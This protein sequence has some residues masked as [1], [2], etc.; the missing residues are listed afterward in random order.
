MK[1]N[2]ALGWFAAV[3]LVCGLLI[4]WYVVTRLGVGIQTDALFAGMAVPQLG[5]A[6]ISGS[7]ASVLVPILSGRSQPFFGQAAW[8]FFLAIAGLAALLTAILW[9]TAPIWVSWLLPG[10]GSEARSLTVELTRIQLFG[11]VFTAAIAVL[12]S[13]YYAEHRFLRAEAAPVLGSLLAFGAVVWGLPRFGIRMAAWAN[14]GRAAVPVLL[15]LPG[16]FPWR[17]PALK[18]EA[19]STAWHRL[20][21]LLV[22]NTYYKVDPLVDRFLSS[23]AGP[24]G[25]SIL[26][27]GQQIW[28][29]ASQILTKA[30]AAPMVPLLAVQAKAETWSVFQSTWRRRAAWM[31]GLT[32]FGFLLFLAAGQRLLSLL[33][34]HGGV[35][36]QNVSMLWRIMVGLVGVLIA[37]SIGQVT[38]ASFYA[39]GD[40]RTPTRLGMLTF[41][42]YVP[43]KILAFSSFGLMG[44]AVATSLFALTNLALQLWYLGGAMRSRTAA[45]G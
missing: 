31:A 19:V 14:V 13:V 39:F 5:L 17:R 27:L 35:T 16:L 7:L 25:L 3:N 22:G 32:A 2:L 6:V 11:L 15:L 1:L 9:A 38:S 43:A 26:Y 37:G 24:G 10:F 18:S 36:H 20:R 45:V 30:I 4:Q 44:V 33:I 42:I 21:P 23:M 12:W 34:G 8:T 41:T 40:T 29:A 28:G